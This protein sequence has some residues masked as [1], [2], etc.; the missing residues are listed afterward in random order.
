MR[1]NLIYSFTS[2]CSQQFLLSKETKKNSLEFLCMLYYEKFR[3]IGKKV[4][5]LTDKNI[6]FSLKRRK[7]P[8]RCFKTITKIPDFVNRKL[9]EVSNE[10]VKVSFLDLATTKQ[11]TFLKNETKCSSETEINGNKEK[12]QFTIKNTC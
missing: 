1:A 7:T 3:V 9:H 4:H 6:A 8:K 10:I 11:Q 12:K 2:V 5:N